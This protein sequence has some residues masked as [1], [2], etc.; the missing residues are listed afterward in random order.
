VDSLIKIGVRRN[1][2]RVFVSASLNST[3]KP[4]ARS[5]A[6]IILAAGQGKRMHSDL[7]KVVHEVAGRAMVWWVVQACREAGAKPIVLV[8]G[9]GAAIVRDLFKNERD[10][11]FVTQEPQLGTGHAVEQARTV[12]EGGAAP[13]DRTDVLVLAGDGPLIRA[14][15]LRT[16]V[17]LHRSGSAAATLATSVIP[18]PTGYGRIV[19]DEAGRFQGI[20]EHKDAS[21]RER[22]IGEINP[23]YYCFQAARLF[24]LLKLVDNRNAS[25]EY[26]ITDVLGHMLAQGQRVE[27]IDAVPPE[28]VTCSRSTRPSN[29]PRSMACCARD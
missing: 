13:I 27:V 17:D 21:P 6:A 9:H 26:Y 24:E 4:S 10:I 1:R 3:S 14:E 8:V 5:L 23:S 2:K 28:D 25:G 16:M 29:W 20:V 22:A 12:F 7:P 11:V 18:D 19:R 15:T